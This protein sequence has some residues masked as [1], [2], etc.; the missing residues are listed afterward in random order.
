MG[1]ELTSGNVLVEATGEV[2]HTLSLETVKIIMRHSGS[3]SRGDGEIAYI[4]PRLLSAGKKLVIP[5][6]DII[7]YETA[8]TEEPADA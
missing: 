8:E 2:N 7:G 5:E 4:A 6:S 3:R 1:I